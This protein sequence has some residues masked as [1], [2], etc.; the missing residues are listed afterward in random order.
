MDTQE[1][2]FMYNDCYICYTQY[3][4]VNCSVRFSG[5][6]IQNVGCL[7]SVKECCKCLGSIISALFG[8]YGWQYKAFSAL[9]KLGRPNFISGLN[10]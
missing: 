9:Y 6:D 2:C 8:G 7:I 5:L 4:T 3:L 10:L 1:K